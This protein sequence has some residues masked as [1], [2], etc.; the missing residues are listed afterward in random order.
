[1]RIAGVVLAVV[2]G[3]SVLG[4]AQ[5]EPNPI[6]LIHGIA[7]FAIP[8]LGQYLNAEYNKALVHFAV[9]VVIVVGG[10][11]VAAI[12]PPPGVPLYWG[13]GLVHTL[14]ALYSGWDAYAVALRR[15]GLAIQVSPLGFAFRF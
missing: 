7:S 2:V 11:Y 5:T 8:G 10:G 3:L 15:E 13:V 9:D 12:L 14:W 6:P 1:M 4:W